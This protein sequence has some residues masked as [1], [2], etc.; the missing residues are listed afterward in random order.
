MGLCYASNEETLD[1]LRLVH[2]PFEI[3]PRPVTIAQ[4]YLHIRDPFAGLKRSP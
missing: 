4:P 2:R 1:T 3:P